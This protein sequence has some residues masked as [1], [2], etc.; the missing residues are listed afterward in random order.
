VAE[1]VVGEQHVTASTTDLHGLRQ[2]DIGVAGC[3]GEGAGAT[4]GEEGGVAQVGAGPDP[5]VAAVLGE[6]VGEQ[7]PGEQGERA[8]RLAVPVAVDVRAAR[9]VRV[10]RDVQCHLGLAEGDLDAGRPGEFCGGD[11]DPA[12]PGQ[13]ARQRR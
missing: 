4:G 8:G 2:L 10:R 7:Q 9:P 6:L 13:E 3:G 1:Q 5:Q 11:Q 12:G